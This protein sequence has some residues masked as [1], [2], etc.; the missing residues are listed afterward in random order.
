MTASRARLRRLLFAGAALAAVALALAARWT[1]ALDGAELRSVDARFAVRGEQAPPRDL[2]V[3]AIDDVTF[4]ELDLQW[5]FPRA[6]HGR[7]LDRLREAGAKVVALDIQFTERSGDDASDDALIDAVARAPGTVLATTETTRDGSS[8]VFGGEEVLDGIGA[9]SGNALM[10]ADPGGFLRRMPYD[11]GG[12]KAFALVTAEQVL[13]RPIDRSELGARTA[14][15]DFRGPP[16]SIP[17]HSYSRVLDGRVPADALRGRIVV[18][19]PTAPSLQDVHPTSTTRDDEMSGAEIQAHAIHTALRG[20][21]LQRG[22]GWL[23]HL[24]IVLLGSLGP[25]ALMRLR[26]PLAAAALALVAAALPAGVQLAFGAGTIL[27]LAGPALALVAGA[28][29]GLVVLLVTGAFERQRVRDLFARFVPESVVDE[30]LDQGTRLGGVERDATVMFSDLRGFTGLAEERPPDVVIAI[31][32]RYLTTMSDVILD[33]GGTLVTFLGDGIMAV[34]GA[35]LEQPDHAQR[36]L[37]AARE[38]TGPA[39]AG[40][41][42]RLADEHGLP[43]LSVGIGLSSGSVLSG[44][45]GSEQRMEYTCIGDTTNV[46]ARLQTQTKDSGHAIFAADSVRARLPAAEA[47]GL[48]RVEELAVSGRAQAILVWA[49]ATPDAAG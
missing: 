14:F 29:S 34:F 15:I 38:M 37:A 41:N 35:P 47:A 23:D 7:L 25:L 20:F 17:T 40:L 32:N 24:L 19:G 26:P 12:L 18:V 44:N 8:N 48:T 43:P 10:P 4:D 31:L 33:H 27:G 45:V 1:G 6:L 2:A 39:L 13:G 28:V 49:P 21:P 11:V 16:G 42:R 46:A 36:A 3:V 22:P 5:P 9:R 30:V